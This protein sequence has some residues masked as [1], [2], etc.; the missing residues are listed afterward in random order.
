MMKTT[1]YVEAS[2]HNNDY[3]EFMIPRYACQNFR[4]ID[5][6][7][8]TYTANGGGD[9]RGYAGNTGA[10]S[11][12]DTIT[13]YSGTQVVCQTRG[14]GY[15]SGLKQLS[16]GANSNFSIGSS[17]YQNLLSY[18]ANDTIQIKNETATLASNNLTYID[19][20]K[21]V[22]F[23]LGLDLEGYK[24]MHKAV[25]KGDNKKIKELI[26]TSNLIRCDKLPLRVV[27][28][29]TKTTP[30]VLFRN[31]NV[32]DTF[33]LNR[34]V[35]VIDKITGAKLDDKFQVVYDTYNVESVMFDGAA[36]NTDVP[37]KQVKLYGCDGKYLKEV[38]FINSGLNDPNY[39]AVFKMYG[40]VAM[41]KEVMNLLVNSNKVVPMEIDSPARKQMYLNYSKPNFMCPILSN[42]FGHGATQANQ[43]Y[44]AN[45]S[46]GYKVSN[47]YSYLTLSVDERINQMALQYQRKA[48]SGGAQIRQIQMICLYTTQ[49][50]LSYQDGNLIVAY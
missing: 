3:T 7:I 28:E 19:L 41:N 8:K 39:N 42:V 18:E 32:A 46:E 25:K 5:F 26:R 2:T 33:V 45:T 6:G 14:V 23:F 13:I 40:S 50:T 12:I 22:P 48:F 30:D 21:I 47:Q 29:Y 44:G 17:L 35:L 10:L 43:L 27:I 20:Y 4:L 34:P 49:Q 9:P 24:S 16:D 36:A 1:V 38:S 31:G 37:M 15:L 11:L